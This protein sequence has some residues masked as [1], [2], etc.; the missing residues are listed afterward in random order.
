MDSENVK[1]FAE[2]LGVPVAKLL[3]QLKEAGVPATGPES[4]LTASD[5]AKLLEHLKRQH[6]GGEEKRITLKRKETTAIRA[7]DASG[8]A[9]TVQVEVRKKR[10]LVKKEEIVAKTQEERAKLEAALRAS[11]SPPQTPEAPL[12]ERPQ[13]VEEAAATA[14]QQGEKTPPEERMT[15]PEPAPVVEQ[16]AP[17]VESKGE[18]ADRSRVP[19]GKEATEGQTQAQVAAERK[20]KQED[21]KPQ[22]SAERVGTPKKANADGKKEPEKKV[23]G[24]A[25]PAK[26][27]RTLHPVLSPEEL[28]RRRQEAE[29]QAKLRAIQEAELRERRA[30]EAARQAAK[31]AL[32]EKAAE[33]K[34][35]EPAVAIAPAPESG[36]TEAESAAKN[37]EKEKAKKSKEKEREE[38]AARK[39][40]LKVRALDDGDSS[41]KGKAGKK[42]NGKR[43]AHEE[44][45]G[46]QAP[47]EPVVREVHVPETITVAELAHA[48][49]VKGVDLIKTLMK[50]G[51]MATI[52]QVLDQETAMLAVEEMGHKAVAAKLDDPDAFL[53]SFGA[54]LDRTPEPRP[55]VVTVMGHVD[56]GKTSLLDT[57]RRTKVAAGEAG[58]ITQHIGA[59][60][61][62]TP[63][64]VVTFL[65]TPGHE[66]F[67]AMRARGAQATDVVVLVVAADDG[68]MPQ[69]REAIHHARAANVPIVVAVNKIDKPDANPERVRQELV[70]EGVIPEEYGGDTI[71]VN[72]SA[73]TGQGIDE[74]LDS[75]LLVAEVLELKAPKSGPAKGLVIEARLDRGRGPVATVLVQSGTLKRGDVVL[76]GA[77]WGRVRAMLDENGRQITE[78]GPSMPAEILG[79]EEVPQAGEAFYVLPDERKAREIAL[80]RQGK[81]REQKLAKNQAL[82]LENL[83]DQMGQGDVKKLPIIIKADVQ[84]SAEAL[85]QALAKLSTD[86]VQVQVVH[87][88]VGGITESDVN[89]A[90]ASR[91]VIIGFNVR[92]DANARKLAETF[93]VDIRYYNII[94]D[95]VDEIKA[96]MAGL[97]SP[98][99][100]EETLGLVEVRQTFHVPKVGTVAGC[101][102]LEGLVRRN[103]R[104]RVLRDNIVIHEGELDSLKRFKEDVREVK[105]GYEC[106]LS[107]KNFQDIREGDQIEVFEVKEVARTL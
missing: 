26:T 85:S 9:R 50:M 93:D 65:D 6:G 4:P 94:Y 97:L 41:W 77:T 7:T 51:V 11:A 61:V 17:P 58:G 87:A 101:Y 46:F 69:T 104:V 23:T 52:N 83:F 79:L 19:E 34:P 59:Y 43:Q 84:G 31:E 45:H 44:E 70:A 72:V 29:R 33:E 105:A 96:A 35:E 57:I 75:I 22:S 1:A 24:A 64:G 66:A 28:E 78:A 18:G 10:V 76:A 12:P 3:A 67:T 88:G 21:E 86:E 2:E 38:R 100:K 95:A 60:H 90:Q 53:E 68:V 82:K 56:H 30:R 42:K 80:Y 5:K 13:P 63:K 55:P 40:G 106:G 25:A 15:A 91:A 8:R 99:R 74:L 107:I 32:A 73:K 20:A 81:Y 27:D 14:Q 71:F 54:D 48:M 39:G 36:T 92:A 62:E 103:A 47:T 102:V 37:K 98:E 16:V 49:A 89:L